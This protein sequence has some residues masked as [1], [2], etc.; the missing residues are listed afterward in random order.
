[1]TP[2]QLCLL[3]DE[4]LALDPETEWV[5]C[6]H[7]QTAPEM[8]AES[9][10]AIANAAVLL[11]RDTAYIIWGIEDG[12]RYVEGTSFQPSQHF[13]GNEKLENWLMRSL[14][15]QID[16]KMHEL[17]YQSLP[18]VLFE[19]P[20]AAKSPV[21]YGKNAFIR[22][23]N[24]TK[25]LK[26]YPGIEKNLQAAFLKTPFE[27]EIAKTNL[28]AEQ[29]LALLDVEHGF[30]LMETSTPANQ[31]DVFEKLVEEKLV[32]SKQE[33]RFDITNLGAILLAKD[34]QQFDHLK[35]K[36][37][38][39]SKYP[40]DRKS[41]TVCL[42]EE[43]SSQAGY[44]VAF[45]S[46][47]EFIHSQIPLIEP[48]DYDSRSETRMY[49]EKAIRELVAN[50]IIHQDFSAMGTGPVIEIFSQRIEITNPGEPL[51]DL[52]RFIDAAPRTRNEHLATLMQRMKICEKTGA[53]IDQV[54]A[55]A[56][57]FQL[58]APNFVA[59]SKLTKATLFA[60]QRLSQMDAADRIRA[61]YQH[62]C[63]CRV[64]GKSMTHASFRAR[65][66]IKSRSS[67]NVTRTLKD[68]TEEK[69]IRPLD[70]IQGKRHSSYLPFWA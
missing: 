19:I 15:P 29:V 33:N 17:E 60:Y 44:A 24:R 64:T 28:S 49:P 26:D 51:I 23:G 52:Q 9:I 20:C 54:I 42:W 41:E 63:L 47:I 38:R 46:A 59:S 10:S 43:A 4:L 35:S 32:V 5:E 61:C 18:V 1:M 66:G 69:L 13:I 45:E 8:I 67:Y 62:A 25:K 7:N 57:S 37:L 53:G 2:D 31:Q 68:A 40:G 21:K 22:I 48:N 55:E 12:S 65:F 16:I 39:I 14:R 58:P 34:L 30:G 6:Q 27:K 36:A 50:A 56:E 3:L 70:P 11:G